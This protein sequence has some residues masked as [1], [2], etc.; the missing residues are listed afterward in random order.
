MATCD[1]DGGVLV[2][3]GAGRRGGV[4]YD[5]LV[6]VTV[7]MFQKICLTGMERLVV[8]EQTQASAVGCTL[9]VIACRSICPD[10]VQIGNVSSIEIESETGYKIESKDDRN[11][12]LNRDQNRMPGWDW[13]QESDR[14]Q[15]KG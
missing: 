10:F 5:I 6:E 7:C 1:K 11:L 8:E 2:W 12:E 9:H 3:C 13:N 15:N 4:P 14:C